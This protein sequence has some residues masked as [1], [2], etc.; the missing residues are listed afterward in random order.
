[1]DVM[2]KIN[3]LELYKTRQKF[4]NW[5]ANYDVFNE[6]YVIESKIMF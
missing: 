3:K 6:F 1:M 4:E 5:L 2:E